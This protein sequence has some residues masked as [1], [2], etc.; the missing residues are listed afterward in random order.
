MSFFSVDNLAYIA[1]NDF[2]KEPLL[3]IE[4]YLEW[5][6]A[7][8]KLAESGLLSQAANK[9]LADMAQSLVL[10]PAACLDYFDAIYLR[11]DPDGQYAGV[12]R[13]T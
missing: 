4:A 8:K 10:M 9:A 2:L 11:D 12:R 6:A 7:T 5:G 3:M 1:C 13:W